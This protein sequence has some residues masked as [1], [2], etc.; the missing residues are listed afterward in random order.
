MPAGS[1]PAGRRRAPGCGREVAPGGEAPSGCAEGRPAARLR[2]PKGGPTRRPHKAAAARLARLAHLTP[3]RGG[4]VRLLLGCCRDRGLPQERGGL[5]E[6]KIVKCIYCV[7]AKSPVVSYTGEFLRCQEGFASAALPE[8]GR[9][10]SA[11]RSSA[12]RTN[13]S[14]S[15]HMVL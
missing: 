4:W 6:N 1:R 13:R 10:P 8:R 11:L 15:M 5:S 12:C 3:E 9:R 14:L 2:A 7:R